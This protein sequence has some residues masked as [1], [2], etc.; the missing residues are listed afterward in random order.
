MKIVLILN[1]IHRINSFN[2]NFSLSSYYHNKYKKVQTPHVIRHYA[3]GARLIGLSEQQ[4]RRHLDQL[5]RS[6]ND[7][8]SPYAQPPYAYFH[9]GNKDTG[10]GRVKLENVRLFFNSIITNI[11]PNKSSRRV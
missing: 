3:D 7:S 10:R 5:R 2:L 9:L 4:I 1:E 6:S 11:K 8:K